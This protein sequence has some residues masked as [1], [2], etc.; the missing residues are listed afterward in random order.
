M[1]PEQAGNWDWLDNTIRGD[2]L[3]RPISLLNLF[4]YTG[5]ST[6]VAAAAGAHVT[7]VDAARS[8]VQWARANAQLS[9]LESYPIR[10]INEDAPR[11]VEREIKR[12]RK[13]DGVILD[14]PSY[15]HGAAGRVWKFAEQIE[16]LLAACRE[17]TGGRPRLMLL[18]C[19]T[20]GVDAEDAAK[21]VAAALPKG[22][23]RQI[24][25]Q[26][27]EILAASGAAARLRCGCAVEV[28][29]VL[30]SSLSPRRLTGG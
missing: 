13:Y 27:L 6:L 26:R 18:T 2:T 11:F 20:P 28:C 17:L 16:P 12:G 3:G 21:L 22:S 1:F 9:E 19:H 7:H 24:E 29:G 8:T 30:R 5:A 10:W 23:R 15:G 25:A 14:P 4:A